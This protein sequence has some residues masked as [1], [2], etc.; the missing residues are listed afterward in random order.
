MKNRL[1]KKIQLFQVSG[2]AFQ[3]IEY[4]GQLLKLH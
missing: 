4:I 1:Q 3:I 2:N